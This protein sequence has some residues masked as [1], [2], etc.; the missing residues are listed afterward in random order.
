[1][2]DIA[3]TPPVVRA[4]LV[5][6]PSYAL[7]CVVGAY[8]VVLLRR[9]VD[10]RATG[11]GNAGARNVLRSGDT[12]GAAL[13]F[14]WDAAKAALAVWA[15]ARLTGNTQLAGVALLFV[16]A[17]HIWPAQLGFRGGRGVAPAIGGT[18]AMSMLGRSA[19]M[20]AAALLTWTIVA[21][22]HHPIFNRHR[23][24]LRRGASRGD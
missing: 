6:L 3:R 9:G 4:A 21:L 17:G 23:D 16:V 19:P 15:S 7:G 12:A 22:A 18:I 1:M 24:A 20:I 2:I 10:V 14:A 8:Y 11:S 5:A 13:T